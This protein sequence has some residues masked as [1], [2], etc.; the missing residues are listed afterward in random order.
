[1]LASAS[2]LPSWRQPKTEVSPK[3]NTHLVHPPSPFCRPTFLLSLILPPF[4]TCRQSSAPLLIHTLSSS[5]TPASS[6]SSSSSPSPSPPHRTTS[7]KCP[8]PNMSMT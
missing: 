3:D 5:L 8:H 4:L 1:M 2:D 6:S 7:P